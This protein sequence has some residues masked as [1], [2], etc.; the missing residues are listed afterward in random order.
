MSKLWSEK[1]ERRES[2]S[3]SIGGRGGTTG[4][5]RSTGTQYF[6]HPDSAEGYSDARGRIPQ[7]PA[8]QPTKKPRQDEYELHLDLLSRFL[9][10]Y[11]RFGTPEDEDDLEE[12]IQHLH[13]RLKAELETAD[14]PRPIGHLV[15]DGTDEAKK[16]LIIDLMSHSRIAGGTAIVLASTGAIW[17]S[18]LGTAGK[19]KARLRQLE[20][21]SQTGK[22]LPQT[23]GYQIKCFL[24]FK[25]AQAAAD[26]LAPTTWGDLAEKLSRFEQWVGT[27]THVS[28]INGS[29][30]KGYYQHLCQLRSEGK[31]G[32]VRA[33]T[34]SKPPNS[35][36]VGH[37]EKKMWS[38]RISLEISTI[39]NCDSPCTST[40]L[41]EEGSRPVP[42]NFSRSRSFLRC[43]RCCR[44][45][46]DFTCCFA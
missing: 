2:S 21:I 20:L 16:Q 44:K 33:T 35:G 27:N 1:Q 38:L 45:G 13:S 9:D 6:Q 24:D 36:F 23:V 3:P 15:A 25:A 5:R 42:S 29:T 10:W 40:T 18:G 7:L 26:E 17:R 14:E 22:R 37:G 8:K 32:R 19:W 31:I 39:P 41:R 4:E 12:E 46:S 11:S 34:C 30:V 43:S 28:T